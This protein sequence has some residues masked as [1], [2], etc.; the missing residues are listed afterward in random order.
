MSWGGGEHWIASGALIDLFPDWP[1]E[2]FPQ[3]AI[4]RSRSH[5]A[6]KVRAFLDFFANV[7]RTKISTSPV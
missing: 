7:V 5:P 1:D 6:A 4:Y 2:T 3:F